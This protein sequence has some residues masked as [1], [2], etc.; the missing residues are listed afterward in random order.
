M[1]GRGPGE[2][3][4][5]IEV[6]LGGE[7]HRGERVVTGTH[8]LHQEVRFAGLREQDP[9]DYDRGDEPLMR[10]IA[11][12]MLRDLVERS[13]GRGRREPVKVEP[14]EKPSRERDEK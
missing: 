9:N 12:A 11:T 7:R 5:T 14:P 8:V 1:K 3:V 13:R 10:D 4:E 6:T 2:R